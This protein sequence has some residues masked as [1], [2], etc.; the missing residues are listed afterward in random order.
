[1]PFRPSST[2]I[3][4][5]RAF[6]WPAA[7]LL[8]AAAVAA[9]AIALLATNAGAVRAQQG[10]TLDD[11]R[12]DGG[13]TPGATIDLLFRFSGCNAPIGG[14]ITITLHED[15]GLPSG[16]DE[17]N[18]VILT[19]L[20]RYQPRYAPDERGDENEIIEILM[21]GCGAWNQYGTDD[22]A[23]C[24]N[25]GTLEG[26]ELEDIILPNVP[27]DDDDGYPVTITWGGIE[28]L[29][30]KVGVDPALEVDGDNE[31]GYGETIEIDGLGFTDGVSVDLYAKL[32]S[33]SGTEACNQATGSGW[34]QIGDGAIVGSNHRFTSRFEIKSSQFR[35]SGRY[36]ICAID[37]A[38]VVSVKSPIITIT[39]G[40]E[41]VGLSE[42][43][44]GDRV[45]LKIVGGGSGVRVSNVRVAGRQLQPGQWSHSGDN[46]IVTLPPSASGTVTIGA[47]LGD[48]FVS[49]NITIRDADLSGAAPTAA[50]VWESSSSSAPTA[51]LA[52]KSVR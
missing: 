13:T 31:V 4:F 51:W 43:S 21:P 49:A 24:D 35:S 2:F 29:S 45:T 30:G 20:G 9:L 42:V 18:V 44:P 27:A 17:D 23:N 6:V 10:C 52:M 34:T 7:G 19:S 37:G 41:V 1:M 33:G 48:K 22:G 32:I 28:V 8:L 25:V 15:I 46:I 16:F 3:R 39:A 5:P 12:Q 50:S 26:I 40:L 47:T 38:G 14:D 11:V 36:Q